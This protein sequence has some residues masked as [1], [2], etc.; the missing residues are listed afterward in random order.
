MFCLH[1]YKR[2]LDPLEQVLQSCASIEGMGTEPW[3]LKKQPV[4]PT[5]ELGILIIAWNNPTPTTPAPSTKKADCL[6][7]KVSPSVWR[8]RLAKDIDQDPNASV[9]ERKERVR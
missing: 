9:R 4:L 2:V 7:F 8:V 6:P 1:V 5:T 3:S